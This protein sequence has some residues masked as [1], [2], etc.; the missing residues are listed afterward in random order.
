MWIFWFWLKN[1]LCEFLCFSFNILPS[2]SPWSLLD[3]IWCDFQ[4]SPSKCQ[5]MGHNIQPS[6]KRVSSPSNCVKTG[7]YFHVPPASFF[8]NKVCLVYTENIFGKYQHSSSIKKCM[9]KLASAAEHSATNFPYFPNKPIF[10]WSPW[11][12]WTRK[13]QQIKNPK[14]VG[15]DIS[16]ISCCRNISLLAGYL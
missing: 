13:Y 5:E 12:G 11:V 7:C 16:E 6:Q 15:Q 8:I 4:N 3:K 10:F 1:W 9:E 2:N 14:I